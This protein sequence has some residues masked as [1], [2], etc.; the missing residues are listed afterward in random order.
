MVLHAGR[1]Q[2][3]QRATR[4]CADPGNRI[5]GTSRGVRHRPHGDQQY[6]PDSELD[7]AVM[8]KP[9]MIAFILGL[10]MGG[11][12]RLNAQTTSNAQIAS[13]AQTAS[14]ADLARL[15]LGRAAN[16][17]PQACWNAIG[18]AMQK[19]DDHSRQLAFSNL[20]DPNISPLCGTYLILSSTQFARANTASRGALLKSVEQKI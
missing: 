16:K 13:N 6:E 4:L 1:K 9:I 15:F 19:A 20:L 17:P 11:S 14:T 8:K 18:Q 2:E 10:A 12:A 7:G 5:P 3:L